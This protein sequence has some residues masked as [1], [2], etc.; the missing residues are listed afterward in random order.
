MRWGRAGR[1]AEPPVLVTA[2]RN[3]AVRIT[4]GLWAISTV[5]AKDSKGPPH[6][7]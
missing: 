7:A 1:P 6:L 2:K 4:R 3:A 5:V